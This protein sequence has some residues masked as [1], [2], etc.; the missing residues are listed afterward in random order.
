MLPEKSTLLKKLK[1]YSALTGS[2]LAAAAAADGQIIYTDINPDITLNTDGA[3]YNLDLNNDG[4]SDYKIFVRLGAK[5]KGALMLPN[6]TSSIKQYNAIGG[7]LQKNAFNGYY[8]N[9]YAYS[10]DKKIGPSGKFFDFRDLLFQYKGHTYFFYANLAYTYS[11]N[12]YGNWFNASDM[13]M[14]LRVTTKDGNF[15][16]WLRCDVSSN[17]RSITLKD[18]AYNSVADSALLAGE[19]VVTGIKNISD[20]HI[21]AFA[22]DRVL[23]VLIQ[24][25]PVNHASL[26]LRNML[27][28][29]VK[30]QEIS[31]A[32]TRTD[33]SDLAT[34]IYEATIENNGK[35]F[36]A[37]ISVQK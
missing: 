37:K 30:K 2:L 34:G 7:S 22:H 14:P 1:S 17:G 32:T 5:G 13:Y 20:A 24:N 29:V 18:Y 6:Y 23:N 10:L 15:Y 21:K 11:G 28:E 36:T 27:G 35:F 16:G 25:E 12:N 31:A 33:I 26:E 9:P 19:G 3:A 8:G 4:V